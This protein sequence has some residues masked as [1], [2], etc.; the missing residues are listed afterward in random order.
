MK[1][2]MFT[3]GYQRSEMEDIFRDAKRF[4]YD[5]IE[6]WGGRP[7][8]YPYDLKKGKLKQLLNLRDKYGVPIKVY[9][10]EHNS[11]PYNYMI[12]DES[13]RIESIEYLK[14]AIEMGKALGTEYTVISAGHAG[15]MASSKEIWERLCISIRE[16]VECAHQNDQILLIEALTQFESNVCT[17]AN[18]LYD[19]VEYI[20]SPQFGAMC[21]LV[22]PYVHNE[23]IMTYFRKL[24]KSLK[25]VHIIDSDG[26][27]DIHLVPG[28]GSIPLKELIKEIKEYG[29]DGGA[30]IELVTSYINEPSLYSKLAID[31]LKN[32]VDCRG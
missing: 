32:I 8:A 1:I 28:E 2:G 9:T 29:Y 16:L 18:D 27:S 3:S 13:Q 19:I 30:T 24:G 22:P 6:L 15:Y 21:D 5:Y 25:H 31:R 7:H 12:G 11:Y 17:N 20:N 23:S 4:N 14:T 10:P 26:K